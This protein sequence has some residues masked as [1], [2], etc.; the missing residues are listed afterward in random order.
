MARYA[1]VD[2]VEE[3]HLAGYPH[4][5]DRLIT[6]W[7]TLG[8]LD[9]ASLG[10]SRGRGGGIPR[11][12]PSAQRDL[13]LEL[14]RNKANGVRSV[15]TLCNL[16]VAWWLYRG[17]RVVPLRQ[18]KRALKTW[19]DKAGHRSWERS[20]ESAGELVSLFVP[21]LRG[22]ERADVVN[23]VA[24][25]GYSSR[26][27]LEEFRK[28]LRKIGVGSTPEETVERVARLLAALAPIEAIL[29]TRERLDEIPDDLYRFARTELKSSARE[30]VELL[31]HLAVQ[32]DI[33][34][35]ATPLTVDQ[36]GNRACAYLAQLL[37]HLLLAGDKAPIRLPAARP[38]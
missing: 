1:L 29:Y 28:Q 17:D 35:L 21:A 6:S 15:A 13:L 2:M 36:L 12:W 33:G 9:E 7:V 10:R 23:V 30:Y 32:P 8:L 14:L 16:P 37:G 34:H 38:R 19:L 22:S 4:V 3:T 24:K 18:A 27:D 11:Y 25:I 5:R 20:T 31:P 26:F